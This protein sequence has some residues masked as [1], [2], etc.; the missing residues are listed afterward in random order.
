[1]AMLVFLL[2]ISIALASS[3]T[4][5]TTKIHVRWANN[6]EPLPWYDH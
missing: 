2:L 1:M 3:L 6:N 5:V 4:A